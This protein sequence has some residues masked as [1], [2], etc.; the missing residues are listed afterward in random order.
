[1]DNTGMWGELLKAKRSVG[2]PRKLHTGDQIG[3]W[4]LLDYKPGAKKPERISPRW[5]CRCSCGTE[6]W[7]RA[8]NLLNGQSQ[9]CGHR[10][11]TGN[12]VT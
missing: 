1:M 8:S 4:V 10:L 2:S 12:P 11:P 9:S 3:D 7:V 6:R 5:W